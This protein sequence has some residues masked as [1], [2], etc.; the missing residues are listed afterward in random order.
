[1]DSMVTASSTIGLR[2]RP[3]PSVGTQAAHGAFWTIFFSVLNKCV[4]L[5]S[6]IA[7]AWFLLPQDL[8]LVAMTFSITS[9][10]AMICGSN[11]SKILIQRPEGFAEHAGQVFWLSLAL[12]VVAAILLALVSPLAGIIFK[13]PRVTSLILVTALTIPLMALPTV[14]SASLYHNLQFKSIAL[15]HCGEG[16]LRNTAS[17]VLAA[18]DF[19]PYALVL[20]LLGGA[21]YSTVIF[22]M[23][24]GR[25]ALG[26]PQPRLWPAL[27]GPAAWLMLHAL[28]IAVQ[29]YGTS[30]VIG[31]VHNSTVTGFYFWGFSLSTQAMF[32]LAANLQGV[33]FP[34]L[35]KVN[36]DA[37]RQYLAFRKACQAL[38]LVAIPVCALQVLLARPLIE[39]FF[40]ERWLPAAPVVQWLSLGMLTQPL[41]VLAVSLLLAQGKYGVLALLTG[42]TAL[43]VTAA[44]AAGALLGGEVAIAQWSC[45]SLFVTGLIAGWVALRQFEKGW[46]ELLRIAG[47]PLLLTPVTILSGWLT[48]T[49]TRDFGPIIILST[50]ALFVLALYF[51]LVKMMMPTVVAE[52]LSRI[53]LRALRGQ[54]SSPGTPP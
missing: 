36:D 53:K 15:I 44:A 1:M 34:V 8:G 20:P 7:L 40:H 54:P 25:I 16:I 21:I 35:S 24:A 50:T 5:G 6:Q 47:A 22:R 9:V 2:V 27:F 32:L 4:T 31:I 38:T 11:L 48:M 30:F 51:V 46:R 41:S 17:V 42:L 23:K 12:N 45:A 29:T 26:V 28:F 14:Y 52:L 10:V 39:L 33:L 13:E 49:A 3:A 18:L 19:G 37:S 43:T